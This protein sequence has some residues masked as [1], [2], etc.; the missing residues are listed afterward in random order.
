MAP[1]DRMAIPRLASV[2]H[3]HRNGHGLQHRAAGAA[4]DPL[5]RAAVA[6]AAHDEEVRTEVADAR[7]QLLADLLVM[8]C[9][10]H[11]RARDWILGGV[12]RTVLRSM[13]VPVLM[14]H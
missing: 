9:Y 3:Q 2:R 7:E 5:A 4:Q 12:S 13:T 6:V 8:G 11:S 1:F 10:G 14:A